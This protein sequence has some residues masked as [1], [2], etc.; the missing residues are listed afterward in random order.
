MNL[1]NSLSLL[2]RNC[3]SV[4]GLRLVRL[5][6][7]K[8]RGIDPLLDL[9]SILG[10]IQHPVIFD[11]GANDGEMATEFL[12]H[13]P[14]AKLVAFEPFHD[15]YELLRKIFGARPNIRIEKAALGSTSGTASLNVFSGHR[16]NS[17]LDMDQDPE[18]IMRD[19]FVKTGTEQV[20][21]DTL[22]EFCSRNKIDHIDA[23]KIDTQ[24]YDLNVLKGASRLLGE[25]RVK[26][27]LLE[28]NFIPMYEGQ[29]TFVD[30]HAFLSSLGYQLVDFYNHT[31]QNGYV[32]WCDACYFARGHTAGVPSHHLTSKNM[33]ASMSWGRPEPPPETMLRRSHSPKPVSGVTDD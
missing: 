21:V 9:K 17:L 20:S 15:C 33:G 14:H 31:R 7:N 25:H 23:L 30:I 13:F 3:L 22:D 24:G 19:K 28:V 12:Q 16:M 4:V 1:R 32:A 26:A 27:V 5:S 2:A 6:T 11:V 18:N 8:V 10:G 29:P